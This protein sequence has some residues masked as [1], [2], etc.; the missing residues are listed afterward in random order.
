MYWKVD[1]TAIAF[2]STGQSLNSSSSLTLKVNLPPVNGTCE[3]NLRNGTALF[4]LFTFMCTDWEDPDGLVAR[5]EFLGKYV[6][7]YQID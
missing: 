2:F 3:V 4:T 6:K 7:I 5:Y 1:Y